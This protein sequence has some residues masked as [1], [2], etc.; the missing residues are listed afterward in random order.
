MYSFGI[1][2]GGTNIAIGVVDTETGEI[3]KK[4]SVP[5]K[6]SRHADEIMKDMAGLCKSLAEEM[7]LTIADFAYAG[8][9]APGTIDNETGTVIYSN[10]IKMDMYPIADKLME[11]S[12]IKK[13]YC[14]NDANAAAYGEAAYGASKGTKHSVMITLGTGL[15]SGIVCNGEMVYGSDGFAGEYGHIAVESRQTGRQCGCGR[16]GCL[17]AYVS[18]TGIKR[19]AFELMATMTCDSELRSVPYDKFEAKMLSDA[20]KKNDPI[21]LEAF[22]RTGRVLGE[23]LA[24][25]TAITSPEAIILFGGLANAGDFIMK[26]TYRYMEENQLAVFKG[27]VKLVM[28]GIQDKNV[29]ILGGAALIWKQYLESVIE[30]Y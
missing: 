13:V 5:T 26:P 14:E 17:E 28:S 2:L 9:A 19:T 21:A 12:G 1:D 23:A 11:Y 16:R 22:E 20:A 6:A 3:L 18:A 4:G 27:K 30:N 7:G 8:I 25:L 15:G 29:A 10:N 24:D